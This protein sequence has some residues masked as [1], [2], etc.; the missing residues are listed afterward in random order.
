MTPSRLR[1]CALM[2]LCLAA[3]TLG[4]KEPPP[5]GS[6]RAEVIARYGQPSGTAHIGKREVLTFVEGHAILENGILKRFDVPADMLSAPVPAVASSAPAPVA[7]TANSGTP[8]D[9]GSWWLTDV[10]EARTKAMAQHKPILFLVTGDMS[11]CPWGAQFNA[12]VHNSAEFIRKE[13]PEFVLLRWDISTFFGTKHADTKEE[14]DRDVA[15]IESLPAL[16]T[17]VF[18]TINIPA[19]AI[20]SPD[21]KESTEVDMS[22][23]LEAK[24]DMLNY[25]LRSIDNAKAGSRKNIS[26]VTSTFKVPSL[27]ADD[28]SAPSLMHSKWILASMAL[29]V[30]GLGFRKLKN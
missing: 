13:A 5:L 19:F 16:R 25:T 14:F 23:A 12:S 22:G 26:S 15:N 28:S 6:T 2:G 1:L 17:A 7:A 21:L 18:S 4:A 30:V 9:S 3:G 11:Q 20:V 8:S 27:A 10:N 24:D 29:V